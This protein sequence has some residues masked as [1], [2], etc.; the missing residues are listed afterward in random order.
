[1]EL[2][3]AREFTSGSVVCRTPPPFSHHY[4]GSQPSPA[5]VM[6]CR[7]PRRRTRYRKCL[8]ACFRAAFAPSMLPP[9]PPHVADV[10]HDAA[11]QLPRRYPSFAQLT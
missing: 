6:P 2:H 8:R 10:W 3:T 7:P 11:P 4:Q 5:L 9:L 1:M